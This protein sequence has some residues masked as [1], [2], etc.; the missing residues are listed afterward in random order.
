M[1]AGACGVMVKDGP[2]EDLAAAVRRILAGERVI[3]PALH[4]RPPQRLA[5]TR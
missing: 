1:E 2:V 4:A 5:L 3:H